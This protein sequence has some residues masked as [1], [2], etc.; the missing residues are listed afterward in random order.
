M[1]SLLKLLVIAGVENFGY[2]QWM[3]YY[4]LRGLVDYMRNVKTWGDMERKGFQATAA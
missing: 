1:R 3:S 4:R 2:R